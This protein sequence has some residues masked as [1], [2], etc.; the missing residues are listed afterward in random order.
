MSD[1]SLLLK[2]SSADCNLR[3]QYC[4]YLGKCDLYPAETV[5]RM[6]DEILRKIISS[7]L[8]I[9]QRAYS[10]GWQGGEPT[11]MGLDFFKKVTEYQMEYGQPGVIVANGFQ[12]NATLL[13]DEWAEHFFKYKFLVGV[14]I[15]GPAEVHDKFRTYTDGRGTHADVLKGVSALRRNNVEFNILTLVSQSNVNKPRD[16]FHYLCDMDIK[17]QLFIDKES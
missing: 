13:D 3:C 10:F 17:F 15:D 16:I 9:P 11:L 8:A 7:F 2:P 14:S 4:F 5:H 12:T 6:N 1:F